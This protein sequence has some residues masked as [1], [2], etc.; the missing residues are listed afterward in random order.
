MKKAIIMV[1]LI[2]M[3]SFAWAGGESEGSDGPVRLR[4]MSPESDF[5]DAWL[6]SWNQENPNIQLV[7]EDLDTTKWLADYMSGTSA[8]LLNFGRGAEIPYYVKRGLLLDLTEYFEKST[9]IKMDD[10]DKGGCDAYQ[11]DGQEQGQGSWYGL[12]KDYNNVTA[13]TYNKELFDKA[14]VE[15]PSES[16]PMTYDQFKELARQVTFEEGGN[17]YFGTEVHTSWVPFIASDMAYMIGK[18]LHTEDGQK[19]NEDPEVRDI[20]KYFLRL[21]K[22]GISSNLKHPLSGWAGSA[23]QGGNIAMVQLGYWFG[24]SCASVENY[25][26]KFGWAPAP[27]V[28]KDGPRVTSSLGATGFVISS[29]TKYPD[30]TFAVFEWYIAGEPGI[31]RAKTGWGIPPLKSLQPLLPDETEFDRT[32]KEIAMEEVKY[33]RPPQLTWYARAD[34][35]INEFKAAETA[36]LKGEVTEDGAIDMFYAAINEALALGKEELGE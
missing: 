18:T 9:L 28:S 25:Q 22:E 24:A 30:Q 15:Y 2:A 12:P 29:Q 33:M 31:E 32:R 13:I 21:R 36:Y 14:G 10:I 11:F 23:F 8:D 27:V 17:K 16:E 1:L 34:V 20:W 35:Y 6:K 26:D 3:V 19:M 4:V 5:T 7:R